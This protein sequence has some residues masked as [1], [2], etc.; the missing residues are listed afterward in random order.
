M[1][2]QMKQEVY[3]ALFGRSDFD[4]LPNQEKIKILST[5]IVDRVLRWA[6]ENDQVLFEDMQKIK[7]MIKDVIDSIKREGSG[8]GFS[9]AVI[10]PIGGALGVSDLKVLHEIVHIKSIT[11]VGQNIYRFIV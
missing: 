9:S 10:K 1:G 11:K 7:A 3:D 4:Q 6:D 5:P 8:S 2:K